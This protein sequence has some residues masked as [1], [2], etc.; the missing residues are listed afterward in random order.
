MKIYALLSIM[1]IVMISNAYAHSLFNSETHRIAGYKIQIATDPEIPS[2]GENTKIML[3]VTGS[4]DEDLGEVI[5]GLRLMQGENVIFEFGPQLIQNGHVNIDYVFDKPG[6]YIAEVSIY[7]NDRIIDT[8]FNIGV[9]RTVSMIFIS[10][11][12]IGVFAPVGL[13]LGIKL[14][15]K[16]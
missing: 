8:K 6:Q 9:T 12:I 3:A 16:K 5:L 2:E 7:E 11:V 10:M 14:F 13:I 4:N 15:K 1:L